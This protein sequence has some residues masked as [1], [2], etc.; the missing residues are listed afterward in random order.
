MHSK[1]SQACSRGTFCTFTAEAC[2]CMSH[3]S[4]HEAAT[5]PPGCLITCVEHKTCSCL[6]RA[7]RSVN[8]LFLYS[9]CL[10][11]YDSNPSYYLAVTR[12]KLAKPAFYIFS[13]SLLDVPPAESTIQS[14]IHP[15]G[16]L[17]VNK[18]KMVILL[19]GNTTWHRHGPPLSHTHSAT[20]TQST[21]VSTQSG[22]RVQWKKK[23]M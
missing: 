14:F 1:L 12:Y 18:L 6:T 3:M 21:S 9:C 19:S 2:K 4:E 15:T 17:T 16:S 5:Q 11:C 7:K 20:H 10:S 23:R 8:H 22:D 13:N